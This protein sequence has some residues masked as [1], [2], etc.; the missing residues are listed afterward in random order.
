MNKGARQTSP[1]KS[2]LINA[3]PPVCRREKR[4]LDDA[5]RPP[6]YSSCLP[7]SPP[8]YVAESGKW[9]G[10]GLGLGS[11]RLMFT[12]YTGARP[13]E[14]NGLPICSSGRRR[15]H[16]Q[17]CNVQTRTPGSASRSGVDHLIDDAQEWDTSSTQVGPGER[18]RH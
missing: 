11:E 17:A 13:R 14:R 5:R 15:R 18:I 9:V 2:M 6:T 12:S 10:P 3:T 8:K 4:E 7:R 1:T 16:R